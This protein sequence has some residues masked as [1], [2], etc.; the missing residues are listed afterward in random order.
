MVWIHGFVMVVWMNGI[1]GSIFEVWID[2]MDNKVGDICDISNLFGCLSWMVELWS[3]L[4][5]FR[6]YRF[7]HC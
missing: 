6:L 7:H 3:R 1:D 2:S 5:I 4:G